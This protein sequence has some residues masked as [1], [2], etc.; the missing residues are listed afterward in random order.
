MGGLKLQGP[1]YVCGVFVVC[2]CRLLEVSYWRLLTKLNILATVL[3][4]EV[5]GQYRISPQAG[6]QRS[7]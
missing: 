3:R 5:K 6:G 7:I 1:L 4:L 2:L